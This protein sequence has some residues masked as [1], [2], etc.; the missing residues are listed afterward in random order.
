VHQLQHHPVV[1][2]WS[3]ALDLS[4]SHELIQHHKGF[5]WCYHQG[6]PTHECHGHYHKQK[7]LNVNHWH[8]GFAW[9]MRR[10]AYEAVGGLIDFA[11]CGAG[12]RHM[13]MSILGF[14][15]QS[16]HPKGHPRYLARVLTWQGRARALKQDLGYVEGLITH[17]WHGRKRDRRY[18]ERW[19]ILVK[20]QFN[21]DTDLMHDA[22]G[23]WQ[24][25]TETPRQWALRDDL[26][27]Y[28]ASR[29]EDSI[30]L[31]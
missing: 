17:A 4:P 23:L 21:P 20:H 24:L 10:D 13:A 7:R 19:Q 2:L 15:A 8:P 18:Q 16:C 11:I 26:R 27:R 5:V 30:D 12:D 3:E 1:Q 22:S 6:L 29:N 25:I 9:G 31:D 14:G 28:M